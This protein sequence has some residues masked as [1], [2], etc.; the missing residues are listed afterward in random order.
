MDELLIDYGISKGKK[1][2]NIIIG[3]YLLLFCL[4]FSVIEGVAQRFSVLF[5]CAIVGLVLAAILILSSTLWLPAPI[6][7]INNDIV[8]SNPATQ[9]SITVNWVNVSNVNIG[10]SY[11]TFHINGGQKQ[12]IIDLSS[13]IYKDVKDIKSKIVELCEYKNIPFHND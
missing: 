9:K 4:Y 10:V 13:I 2:T 12:Q 3:S 7:K 11:I 5:F 8:E 1:I 6:L